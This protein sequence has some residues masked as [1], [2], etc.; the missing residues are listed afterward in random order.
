[1]ICNVVGRWMVLVAC[2]VALFVCAHR[3]SAVPTPNSTAGSVGFDA[4]PGF[5]SLGAPPATVNVRASDSVV[6]IELI[7]DDLG[8]RQ[9]EF[10]DLLDDNTNLPVDYTSNDDVFRFRARFALRHTMFNDLPFG[11]FSSDESN[12]SFSGSDSATSV[13]LT[14][15]ESDQW[16][17]RFMGGAWD[18]PSGEPPLELN[19]WY[20]VEMEF[21][22]NGASS[23]Q[24]T[25]LFDGDGTTLIK[26]FRGGTSGITKLNQVGIGNTDLAAVGFE[27]NATV[28][29]DWMTWSVNAPLPVD[30]PYAPNSA[31]P[32]PASLMLGC[33]GFVAWLAMSRIRT[34]A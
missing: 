33:L 11:F 19:K 32:E 12:F 3:A 27:A 23:D 21:T 30:P 10:F 4:A 6:D 5:S 2:C 29:L 17:G 14:D 1:M 18:R 22:P 20:V 24:P 31:I 8:T 25:K 7:R 13:L 9:R 16:P 15:P 34:R 26:D 28:S